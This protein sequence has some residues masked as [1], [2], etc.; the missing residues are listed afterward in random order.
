MY[1]NVTIPCDS[2]A[3]FAILGFI[4]Y[5]LQRLYNNTF[6]VTEMSYLCDGIWYS[7]NS[8]Q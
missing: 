4:Y 5:T 2:S 3:D 8:M 1:D 6:Y 7:H